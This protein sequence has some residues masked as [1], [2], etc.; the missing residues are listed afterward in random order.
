MKNNIFLDVNIVLDFLDKTRP[1]SNLAKELMYKLLNQESNII[2][3]EDMITTIFY[4]SPNKNKTLNFLNSIQKKWTISDFT[5]IVINDAI[6]LSLEKNLDLEDI[7]QCLCAKNNKCDV[8]ITNDKKF[9]DCGVKI[10]ST[11]E[12]LDEK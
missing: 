6:N 4:L 10:M 8:L 2:I 3:S 11:K 1:S 5:S 9:Y 7:L 12:F